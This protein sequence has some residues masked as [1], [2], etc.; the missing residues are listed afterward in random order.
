MKEIISTD[1]IIPVILVLITFFSV[2]KKTDFFGDFLSGAK[3]GLASAA[4]VLP[5]LC[6]LMTAISMVKAS[7]VLEALTA[8]ALPFIEKFGFPKEVLPLA[9]LRPFSGSGA[10]AYYKEICESVPPDSFPARVASVLMGGSETTFYTL[11]VYY[12]A[13]GIKKTKNTV[14]ASV[15][16]DITAAVLSAFAVRIFMGQ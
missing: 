13:V 3:E 7:G 14:F 6:I 5:A 15:G 11:A 8:A 2:I 10:L 9:V 4:D 16:A 12:G 1:L